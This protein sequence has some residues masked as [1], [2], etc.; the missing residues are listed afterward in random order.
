MRKPGSFTANGFDT[1]EGRVVLS[2]AS[3]VSGVIHGHKA[4]LVAADFANFQSS[5]NNTIA[6][7]VKDL[8]N[9]NNQGNFQQANQDSEQINLAIMNQVNS[10]G[11][12]LA[13]QLHGKFYS[14][15]RTLITGAATPSA[16]GFVSS[17][18]STGSLM[19]TLDTLTQTTLGSP[20]VVNNLVAVYQNAM[21]SGHT[22]K[23]VAGDFSSFESS[24]EKTITPLAESAPNSQVSQDQQ[25]ETAIIT[26]VNGLGTQLSNDLGSQAQSTI[27]NLITGSTASSGV[28]Y[29]SGTPVPGSLLATL[30]SVQTTDLENWD[31]I[32]DVVSVYASSSP[33]FT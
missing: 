32:N 2:N 16:V 31:F 5:L 23:K 4:Q 15:I 10:L 29:V 33:T 9:D 8:Q 17:S 28:N 1:L 12:R 20:S 14:R 7:I 30:T 19:A 25:L 3:A 26:L 11:N 18:P 6:P 22:A 24:F 21:I 27:R 13:K